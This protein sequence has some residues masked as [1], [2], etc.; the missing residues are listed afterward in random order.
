MERSFFNPGR[1]VSRA[2]SRRLIKLYSGALL[3]Y[4]IRTRGIDAV[5][6]DAAALAAERAADM[7]AARARP[8][9][10]PLPDGANET[11]RALSQN[12]NQDSGK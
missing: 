11:A 1:L 4:A 2:E 10:H 3:R 6:A 12:E 8:R 5:L 7:T 9:R